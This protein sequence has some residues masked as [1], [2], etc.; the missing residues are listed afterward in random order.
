M[1][2]KPDKRNDNDV[3]WRRLYYK[4]AHIG[5]PAAQMEDNCPHPDRCACNGRCLDLGP[6]PMDRS[7]D[8]E[9]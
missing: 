6:N 5:C 4:Y 3:L 8:D 1:T 2:T 7:A 9:Q